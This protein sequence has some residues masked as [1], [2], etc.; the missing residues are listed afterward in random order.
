[1]FF[2]LIAVVYTCIFPY[3]GW[4]NN[5]NE[6]VRTYMTMALVEDHTFQV[7]RIVARHGWTNDMALVP[8]RAQG[9]VPHR[10]SV[11][12][13]AVSYAGVP[14]YWVFTKV[15]SLFGHPVPALTSS[16]EERSLW[17]LAATCVLRL[18]VIQIPC[19][20]FL[21]F[22]ERYL[23][24]FTQDPI[25]RLAA[26]TA[27]GLGS[28]F[29]A[30]A[31][32]YV[33]HS[34]FAVAA[35]VSFAI[36]EVERARTSTSTSRRATRAFW[37]G[38]FAGLVT[39]L[40]YHALPV[41]LMLALYATSAFWRPTRLFALA[42]GGLIDVALLM[43]FQWRAFGNPL[44]P[45][46]LMV[47]NP[48][49]AQE[50]H[51]GLYGME[52][53]SWE[54]FRDLSTSHAFGFFGTSP[55]MW[56]G[57]LAIPFGL[58]FSSGIRRTRRHLRIAT[59][60]WLLTMLAL[61]VTVSAANNWRGG[62]TI[63]PRYLGAAPPFFAFGAVIALDMV[64]DHRGWRRGLARGLAVGLA[65]A[66]A[67]TIGLVSVVY[68]TLPQS[69]TR[70]LVQFVIPLLRT[71]FVPYHVGHLVGLAG[72]ASYFTLLAIGFAAPLA[73]M[74][75]WRAREPLRWYLARIAVALLV[76]WI[77][78]LGAWSLPSSEEDGDGAGDTHNMSQLWEPKGNDRI[79]RT[80]EM[81]ERYGTRGPCTWYKLADL[82]RI[83]HW[84]AEAASDERRAT[85]PRSNCSP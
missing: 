21:V 66:S 39:L 6:N 26:T 65:I 19:F 46:H 62:W 13:P 37:A 43:F 7:D 76:S 50:H 16:A 40:E 34:L 31:L 4:I 47:E 69:V 53:P 60:V 25:L 11:K 24:R 45:G 30:Y 32:M 12:A 67:F 51:K 59:L 22:F 8:P 29:L 82:E 52:M 10:Y 85:S 72:P 1:M 15:A 20:F 80:R 56:L 70:P 38:F 73:L 54:T 75:L 55:F 63:G 48:A 27:V 9:D 23:R 42:T 44:T 74:L 28:N 41:S 35:F 17:L 57:L 71:G 58:I 79:T 64:S 61:F 78:L 84:D 5:P 2:V 68:N 49:F 18:F 77:G 36:T 3:M 81:A 33:S 14:V 83:V